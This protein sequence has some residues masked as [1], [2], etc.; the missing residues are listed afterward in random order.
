MM[1]FI[2]NTPR[3]AE[4][5]V[6]YALRGAMRAVAFMLDAACYCA[7]LVFAFELTPVG[8]AIKRALQCTSAT[9]C[10]ENA[11]RVPRFCAPELVDL[12]LRGGVAIA[13]A[14][15]RLLAAAAGTPIPP[16]TEPLAFA[17]DACMAVRQ[18]V[19]IWLAESGID[20]GRVTACVLLLWAA[21]RVLTAGW[22]VCWRVCGLCRK[23]DSTRPVAPA[24]SFVFRPTRARGVKPRKLKAKLTRSKVR[25]SMSASSRTTPLGSQQARRQ[26]PRGDSAFHKLV[27]THCLFLLYAAVRVHVLPVYV[28]HP[29]VCAE[30]ALCACGRSSKFTPVRY[31]MHAVARTMALRKEALAPRRA[32]CVARHRL[33]TR[34]RLLLRAARL[35][36]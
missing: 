2:A 16:G 8:G 20:A 27:R 10:V 14:A 23:C 18:W 4:W 24:L 6:Y 3:N 15:L 19:G 9:H 1:M 17:F 30:L 11:V 31:A 32:Q 12:A 36:L 34:R 28:A 26:L 33:C 7:L 21:M 29:C 13:R 22:T 5:L 25:G 35:R